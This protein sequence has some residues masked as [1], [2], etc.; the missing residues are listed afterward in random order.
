MHILNR[1]YI[2]S[3]HAPGPSSIRPAL[4]RFAY[5]KLFRYLMR[6]YTPAMRK[7][8]IGAWRATRRISV[9][10]DT[11]RQDLAEHYLKLRKEC[12]AP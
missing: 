6:A 3:K 12:L 4:M 9:L 1:A 2:L 10:C 5:Y 11:P 7:R 8:L